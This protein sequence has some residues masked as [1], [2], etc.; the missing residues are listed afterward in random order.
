[1]AGSDDNRTL[2]ISKL[3]G[4]NAVIFDFW[5]EWML[6][7]E[8]SS[9]RGNAGSYIIEDVNPYADDDDEMIWILPEG[10]SQKVV[11][12]IEIMRKFYRQCRKAGFQ[13]VIR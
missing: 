12:D 10:A 1:M 11:A 5:G 8:H 3:M 7:G 4:G 13:K 2:I 9:K 6:V